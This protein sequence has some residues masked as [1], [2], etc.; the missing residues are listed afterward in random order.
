M[1]LEGWRPPARALPLEQWTRLHPRSV[2]R[3][4]PLAGAKLVKEVNNLEVLAK[5]KARMGTWFREQLFLKGRVEVCAV[6]LFPL[7][8]Y[9]LSVLPLPE[10][11]WVALKH[12]LSK[13]AGSGEP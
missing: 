3:P 10:G 12:S 6:Y 4:R 13:D 1:C 9:H 8:L 5:V 11:H 2:V 7:I